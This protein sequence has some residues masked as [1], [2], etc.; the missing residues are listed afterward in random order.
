MWL[1]QCRD[2]GWC[3]QYVENSNLNVSDVH[4]MFTQRCLDVV[5]MSVPNIESVIATTLRQHCL[6]VVSM[7]V[8]NVE[9]DFATMFT[10][11]CLNTVPTSFPDVGEWHCHKIH[12][13]LSERCLNVGQHQPT[14]WQCCGNVGIL[15]KYNIGTTFTQHCLD[16]HTM[17]LGHLNE[18]TFERCHNIGTDIETMLAP[19][20][21]QRCHNVGALS[22]K[23]L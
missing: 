9:S 18:P 22:G 16:V 13:T 10:Q 12:I 14:L 5:S 15:V 23:C 21:W 11:H 19:T 7:L 17:L 6:N 1:C 2:A 4:T 8:S 3:C 20:L